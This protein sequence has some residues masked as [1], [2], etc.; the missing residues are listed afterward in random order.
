MFCLYILPVVCFLEGNLLLSAGFLS[1][2][3][4]FDLDCFALL[5]LVG[6][7][8]DLFPFFCFSL[9]VTPSFEKYGCVVL[10]TLLNYT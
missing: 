1:S 4:F 5:P 8:L 6:H 3:A 10:V 9:F 2:S 7:V